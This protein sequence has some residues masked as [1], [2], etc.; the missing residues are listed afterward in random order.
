MGL[1]EKAAP[2]NLAR[3]RF[4]MRATNAALYDAWNTDPLYKQL[5]FLLIIPNP[6]HNDDPSAPPPFV[7]GI[8]TPSNG[9]GMWDL[10]CEHNDPL[11]DFK[12]YTQTEGPLDMILSWGTSGQEVKNGWRSLLE[13]GGGATTLIPRQWLGYLAST[14][15]Q[16]ESDDPPAQDLLKTFPEKC[17]KY[18]IPCSAMHLSS[19]YTVDPVSAVFLRQSMFLDRSLTHPLSVKPPG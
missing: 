15:G 12:K 18:M 19:G 6:N 16:A 17:E 11:G 9:A 8:Y 14:M 13:T 5:P 1:G 4:E 3:R 10:G 7:Q 2:T